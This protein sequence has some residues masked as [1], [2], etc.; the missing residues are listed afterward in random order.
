MSDFLK[1]NGGLLAVGGVL[2]VAAMGILDWRIDVAMT[3]KLE[4]AGMVSPEKVQGMEKDIQETREQHVADSERMDSK[5]E[6]IVDIL[7]E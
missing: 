3:E 2:W 1:N 7:I 4:A 5:I 6:R